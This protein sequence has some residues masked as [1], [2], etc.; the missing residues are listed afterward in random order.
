[1]AIILVEWWHTFAAK[2]FH[3][4]FSTNLSYNTSHLRDNGT[5]VH[6]MIVGM[7]VES[8]T[9]STL[10]HRHAGEFCTY[11]N[12]LDTHME[13]TRW[14]MRCHCWGSTTHRTSLERSER[15]DLR[16]WREGSRA[17]CHGWGLCEK[18]W[19]NIGKIARNTTVDQRWDLWTFPGRHQPTRETSVDEFT[20]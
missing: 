13:R 15:T 16:W 1:M 17:L 5:S 12:W 4:S 3:R 7:R 20:R 19:A 9:R 11:G 18:V 6:P 8:G 14:G 10:P 2:L